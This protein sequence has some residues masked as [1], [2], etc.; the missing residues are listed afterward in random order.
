MRSQ[1]RAGAQPGALVIYDVSAPASCRAGSCAMRHAAD[2]ADRPFVIRPRCANGRE[3]ARRWHLLPERCTGSTTACMRLRGAGNPGARPDTPASPRCA[4]H[5]L[6]TRRS[7]CGAGRQ[8]ARDRR[9][10]RRGRALRGRARPPRWLRATGKM[11]WGCA[12]LQHNPVLV[13]RSRPTTSR[14]DASRRIRVRLA[15]VA[16]EIITR[17]RPGRP[18]PAAA[19]RGTMSPMRRQQPPHPAMRGLRYACRFGHART[20][21]VPGGCRPFNSRSAS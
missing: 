18:Y 14:L 17:S 13:L 5:A 7:R 2:V 20:G 8:C 19:V 6:S 3:L 16:P 15:Q 12:R 1:R 11:A 4:A 9:P 21:G 10:F